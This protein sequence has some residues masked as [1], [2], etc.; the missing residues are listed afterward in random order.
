MRLPP[1]GRATPYHIVGL[2]TRSQVVRRGL[3]TRVGG[4]TQG[5]S[6]CALTR[7]QWVGPDLDQHAVNFSS[8]RGALGMPAWA[9]WNSLVFQN[10]V[11]PGRHGGGFDGD[12]NERLPGIF[13]RHDGG[14]DAKSFVVGLGAMRDSGF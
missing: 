2:S 8:Y 5:E 14:L 13:P 10:H 12:R 4:P 9:T 6:V 1:G 7:A 3:Y 11:V